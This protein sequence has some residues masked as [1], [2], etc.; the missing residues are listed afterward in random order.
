[1]YRLFEHGS[2]DFYNT[3]VEINLCAVFGK[4]LLGGVV[5]HL[6]SRP[7]SLKRM[8]E[9]GASGALLEIEPSLLNDDPLV[10]RSVPLVQTCKPWK[11]SYST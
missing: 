1:M 5:M 4:Y 11:K 2:A 8:Q 10:E 6:N 9:S 3:A 7:T